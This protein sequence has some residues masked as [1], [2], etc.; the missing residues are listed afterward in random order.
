[1]RVA[2]GEDQDADAIVSAHIKRL[3]RYNE[4]KDATQI[5]IGRLAVLKD[6][7]IRKIHEDYGLETTE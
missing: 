4:A 1:M 6:T 3:H 7:T 2:L 5:L